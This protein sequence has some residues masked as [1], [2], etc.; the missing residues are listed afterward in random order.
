[1]LSKHNRTLEHRDNEKVHWPIYH[2]LKVVKAYQQEKKSREY[3]GESLYGLEATMMKR[4]PWVKQTQLT[5]KM[6]GSLQVISILGMSWMRRLKS[7]VTKYLGGQL[8]HN[9]VSY[10]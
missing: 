1:M 9:R 6:D 4:Y 3:A 2:K 10:V 5:K 8:G 7:N